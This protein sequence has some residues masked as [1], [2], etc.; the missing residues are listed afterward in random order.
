MKSDGVGGGGGIY[1]ARIDVRARTHTSSV[2]LKLRVG[3]E[4]QS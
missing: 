4:Q 2:V 1:W 3:V